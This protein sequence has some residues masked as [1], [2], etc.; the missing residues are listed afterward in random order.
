MQA[1]GS[2]HFEG[3]KCI[4]ARIGKDETQQAEEEC[5]LW[6]VDTSKEKSVLQRRGEEVEPG[7]GECSERGGEKSA[8]LPLASL[9][10]DP[11]GNMV[12]C[13]DLL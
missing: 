7:A 8:A 2:P 9:A 12:D 13:P 10:Q 1:V 6:E 11:L 5:R 4:A 3:K